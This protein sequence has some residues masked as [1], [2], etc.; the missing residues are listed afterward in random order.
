MLQHLL[1]AA[2]SKAGAVLVGV[3][4]V[5]VGGVVVVEVRQMQKEM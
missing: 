2:A 3:K 1:K 4:E 5:A